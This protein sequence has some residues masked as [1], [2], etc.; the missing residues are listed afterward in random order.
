MSL[1]VYM[2]KK[3]LERYE[4]EKEEDEQK[5]NGGYKVEK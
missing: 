2:R 5:R 1:P 4:K 3:L